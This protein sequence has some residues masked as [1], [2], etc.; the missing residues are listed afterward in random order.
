MT[1]A[2]ALDALAQ[3]CSEYAHTLPPVTGGAVL[4]RVRELYKIAT[5]PP[6]PSNGGA[7]V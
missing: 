6:E 5:S 7:E 4:L 3:L 2:Q 1:P